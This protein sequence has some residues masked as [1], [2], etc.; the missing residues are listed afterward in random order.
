MTTTLIWILAILC[1]LIGLAGTVLPAIPGAPIVFVGLLLAAWVDN[2]Q[3]VGWIILSLLGALTVFTLLVD[4]LSASLGVKKIGASSLAIWGALLG[5]LFGIFAGI[6][7]L[8]LGPFVGSFVG[9]LMAKGDL[10]RAGKVGAVTWIALLAGIA[11]KLSII[12]SMIGIFILAYV[13]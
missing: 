4:F 5:T 11:L 8:I 7:G 12:F 1:V 10:L 13:F 3:E 6:P 9:E 2:F